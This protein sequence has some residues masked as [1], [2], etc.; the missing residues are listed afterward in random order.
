MSALTRIKPYAQLLCAAFV[1]FLGAAIGVTALGHAFDPE[2]IGLWSGPHAFF[3]GPLD[4]EIQAHQL[5]AS[6]LYVV[7]VMAVLLAFFVAREL[8][9]FA[10]AGLRRRA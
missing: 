3:F 1:G 2:H 4:G 5:P 7:A 8:V 10:R 9:G 6:T